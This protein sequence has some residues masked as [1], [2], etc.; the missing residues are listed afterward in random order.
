MG[1]LENMFEEL[2][3]ISEVHREFEQQVN[4]LWKELSR[5]LK[6]VG[7][8]KACLHRASF[9]LDYR[10]GVRYLDHH[11]WVFVVSSREGIRWDDH[12]SWAAATLKY[13]SNLLPVTVMT[14]DMKA[15]ALKHVGPL[16]EV[17][18]RKSESGVQKRIKQFREDLSELQINVKGF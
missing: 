10:L 3:I 5:R 9:H 15:K 4:A 13:G 17:L 14:S 6:A 16:L 8:F 12:V 7:P 18:K 2:G 1:R 11:G